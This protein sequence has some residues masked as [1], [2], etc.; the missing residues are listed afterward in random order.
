MVLSCLGLGLG[1]WLGVCCY[2]SEDWAD[3]CFIPLCANDRG[4]LYFSSGAC[5]DGGGRLS[6][7][8]GADGGEMR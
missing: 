8:L 7:R 1:G 5:M 6:E 2:G 3:V 4:V